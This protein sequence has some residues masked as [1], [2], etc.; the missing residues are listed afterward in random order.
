MLQHFHVQLQ[1]FIDC[2]HSS[3]L[4]TNYIGEFEVYTVHY[5]D[6]KVCTFEV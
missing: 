4:A 6:T 3:T 5:M 2:L 1:I